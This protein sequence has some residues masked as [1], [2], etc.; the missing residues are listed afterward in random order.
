M[1][2]AI[3]ML[4]GNVLNSVAGDLNG[5]FEPEYKNLYAKTVPLPGIIVVAIKHTLIFFGVPLAIDVIEYLTPLAL[6]R[7]RLH[8]GHGAYKSFT[9]YKHL[10][11]D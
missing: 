3:A 10:R 8:R 1:Y 6:L 2:Y 5:I 4:F 7:G 11:I 9:F